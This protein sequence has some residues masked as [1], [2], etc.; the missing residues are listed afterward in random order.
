MEFLILGPLEVRD[1]RGPVLLVGTKPRGVLAM[2]LLHANSPV[3]A[4]RLAV[5]LWGEDAPARAVKTVQ[6]HVSRL[7]KALQNGTAIETSP[8]GYCLRLHPGELDA[9]RFAQ[10]TDDGHRALAEGDPAHAAA[11]LR[12]ALALW[13]GPPLADLAGEPFVQA[14]IAELEEQRTSALE[15]RVEAD[16]ALGREAEVAGELQ[17]LVAAHPTRERL[18]QQL[19]LALYRCGR[20]A[21]ALEAYRQTRGR[22]VDEIGV[23]PG[24]DLRRLQAAIL[25]QDGSLLRDRGPELPRELQK[26]A[27]ERLEGRDGELAWLCERWEHA[28]AGAGALVTV[29][30]ERGIGKTR[31]AAELAAEAHSRGARVL[32]A[33]GRGPPATALGV[34]ERARSPS[35]PTLLIVDGA[36]GAPE[37][38]R[39][40]L[41]ALERA[42]AD[43]PAMVV[44]LGEPDDGADGDQLVLAPLD[45]TAVDA[46]VTRYAPEHVSA[47]PPTEWLLGASRGVPR[48]VHELA[49]QWAR[50]EAG[51]RVGVGAERTAARRTD[52]RTLEQ[53]LAADVVVLE[54]AREH[55]EPED[56]DRAV[57]CPFKGLA[58]FQVADAPYF[59]GRERLVAELVARLVGAPLL[60]IVGPSGS[61]KSSVLRAGLL[62]ALAAGV[63]PGSERWH[64]VL[65]RPGAHPLHELRDAL[66][67]T[68]ERPVA[69][70]I[71]Q[72][73]ESFTLCTDD[74]ERTAF[75]DELAHLAREGAGKGVVALAM[76]ADFYGRCAEH[77]ELSRLL[78]ASHVL[79][80]AMRAD[81]LRRAVECPA[82][83]A[84]LIVE[85][86]LVD[87]LVADVEGEPGALPL[88]STALLEQW[89]ERDGRRLRHAAYER[90][91]GVRGAVARLGESAYAPLDQGQQQIA[92]RVLLRLA[93]I[94]ETG[95]VE[96]RRVATAELGDAETARVVGLLADRRLLTISAG[97]VEL[98]HEALLREWPR[99]RGWLDEDRESL[100][101]HERLRIEA[102]EWLRLDRDEGALL[103]G[104]RLVEAREWIDPDALGLIESEREF[105]AAS[106]ERRRRERAARRR[107]GQVAMGALAAAVVAIAFI[108][109]V[110]I[111]QRRDAQRQRDVALSHSLAA[112]SAETLQTSP[113]L[114]LRL[115]L[116]ADQ[117]SST[118]Q[119]A[120]ALRQAVLGFRQLAV[121][122]A[123]TLTDDTAAYSPD[124]ARVVTGGDN[125]VARLWDVATRRSMGQLAPNRGKLLSARYSPDGS[126]I[127]LGSSHG[128]VIVTDARLRGPRQV[129]RAGANTSVNRVVFSRDGKRVAAALSDGT[130]RVIDPAGGA[131]EVTF[132]VPSD[133]AVVGIDMDAQGRVVAAYG[134]G[135]V[136]LWDPET[137]KSLRL[138]GQRPT[139]ERDVDFSPD[140]RLV[141]AVGEDGEARLWNART[142]KAE[143]P[144]KIGTRVLTSGAFSP[145]GSRFATAGWD[146]AVRIWQT[147]GT[148]LLFVL[149]GQLSRLLDVGFGRTADRVV[150]A[151]DDGTARIWNAGGLT[152]F[153]GPSL[154][155]TMDV[156][157]SGRWIATAS[158]DG[159]IR[160]WD[161]ISGRLRRTARGP[162]GYTSARFSP[163]AD[164]LAIGR[165]ATDTVL[166]WPLSE[167]RPRTVARLG[168]GS[169]RV[170]ARFDS[171][172]RRLVFVAQNKANALFVRD[173]QTGREVRLGGAPV[174]VYD[175]HISPDGK[176]VAA[177]T[178][179]G[180][181]LVWRLDRPSAPYRRLRG[182]RGNIDTVDFDA[183]S[184][185]ASSGA[186]QTVRIWDLRTGRQIVLHG[187]SDEVYNASFTPDDKRVIS[188]SNDGTVRLWDPRGGMALAVLQSGADPIYDLWVGKGDMIATLD[189]NEVVRL[190]R[191]QVCGDVAQVRALARSLHP[192]ALSADERRRFVAG[193]G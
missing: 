158:R 98:A 33:D 73:E 49:R 172:G 50:R 47:E 119:A 25:R 174:D 190:F 108:A 146:G 51:R 109:L 84:G 20:Q 168:R 28:K 79:V 55:V 80:G 166:R 96:R 93:T 163:A 169:G 114:A 171:T 131:A 192:R 101:V 139:M 142:G 41:A 12:A 29:S 152:T 77:A 122:P 150:S 128:A 42:V 156:S 134:D 39:A 23:E 66:P 160:V 132:D 37:A 18:A 95:G 91:G 75:L 27:A 147:H 68:P 8:A 46:I 103:R 104:A 48:L 107:R 35:G 143:T 70:A 45:L 92:R 127:A 189:G 121:L 36:D 118:P 78:S 116:S 87:A 60:G 63:L 22:L 30:G 117:F 59:F 133:A 151:G 90:A 94:D 16:L 186:D 179:S 74:H 183:G 15:A 76:R 175:P 9:E 125:G 72:F 56:G 3:S 123:D 154:T 111:D 124:G 120:A 110:A 52:L 187:H 4:D 32:F 129:L 14:E 1:E 62:P 155:Y 64:Q 180:D 82:Q 136:K 100:R 19:M 165:E 144:I 97:T 149:R 57:V 11:T 43:M 181:L 7:R 61:G 89:Q 105:L 153:T 115:A 69:L 162:A 141:L 5:A 106:V 170:Q 137:S 188:T 26:A 40:E 85:P 113:E 157:P 38:V 135:E 65:M 71:D 81:E 21:D 99:L 159:A 184:R 10:L 130:V 112:Q 176:Q 58:A 67:P 138:L 31:L 13:R 44:A 126:R 2:L 83:R 140:G 86:E 185:I 17:R 102:G 148:S 167:L 173:V 164:E 24:P 193:A 6:V 177:G 53:E 191:C 161:A 34:M 178:E 145:D 54:S 88:L 182:H